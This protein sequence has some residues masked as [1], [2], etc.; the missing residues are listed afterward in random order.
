M[1]EAE[2][3]K[4]LEQAGALLEGHFLLTSGLHSDR[5]VQCAL[6]LS[7]PATARALGQGLA[8]AFRGCGATVVAG[9]ALGGIV[10]AHETA[11]ALGVRCIFCE[12]EKGRMTFRRGFTLSMD[13]RVLAVEDVVTTGGS[14]MEL[15]D[16]AE[17][18]GAKVVGVG[19]IVDRRAD[20]KAG[21]RELK[22]LLKL[23]LTTWEPGTCPLCAKGSVA[24][25]P[26]SRGI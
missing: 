1:V 19:S 9:P 13:D 16:L 11:V 15:A 22:S 21:T 12:R 20:K 5:Y 4:H 23:D 18:L 17:G 10:I 2:V 24:V 25:K 6:A 8:D 3:R 14:V 26:G 7:I